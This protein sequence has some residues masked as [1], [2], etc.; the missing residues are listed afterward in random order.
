[1]TVWQITTQTTLGSHLEQHGNALL[2]Q[3]K[4][5]ACETLQGCTYC[6]MSVVL[7]SV[8]MPFIAKIIL[9]QLIQHQ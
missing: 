6:V 9:E 3:L 7:A 2:L 8:Q 1:M 4:H 5:L